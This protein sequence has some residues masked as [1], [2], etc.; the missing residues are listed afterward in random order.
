MH[1]FFISLNSYKPKKFSAR[2]ARLKYHLEIKD[3]D[4]VS[5]DPNNKKRGFLGCNAMILD[6]EQISEA[7]MVKYWILLFESIFFI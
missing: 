7:I 3:Y 5:I 4:Y 2:F 1:I 6:V